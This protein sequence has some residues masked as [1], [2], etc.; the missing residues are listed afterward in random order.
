MGDKRKILFVNDEME[1]GGVARVLNTL[2]SHLDP[3]QYEVDCLVLHKHGLLL[4][5]IPSHVQILSGTSFFDTIDLPLKELIHQK[6]GIKILKKA[7]LIFYM[8]T[9]MIKKKIQA[10]RRKIL[11]KKYDVEFAAKE[12]FCTIFTAYGDSKKKLNW[13]LTDYSVHNY[14]KRH[15]K[16]MKEALKEID[17]NIADSK[18]AL[19]AYIDV[20]DIK[21]GCAIHNLMDVDKVKR[22]MEGTPIV[23]YDLNCVNVISIGRF[24]HQKRVERILYAHEEALKKGMNHNLYLIGGG[25]DE[26][27][28]RKI[29]KDKKLN[30]VFFLGY[31]K[32]P[33]ADLA[34]C[35]LFVLSSEYEGF[36]T[37]VNESLIATT[38]VLSTLV[39][40]IQEQIT[41]EEH[42]WI[43]ENNQESLNEG[44]I[45]AIENQE[46]LRM[47]KKKLENYNYPNQEI[48]KKFIQIL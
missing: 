19:N 2:M 13:V 36:A 22:G 11:K 7:R 9:G 33:Y 15:M 17:L 41:Q 43:V 26:E 21:T 14:S 37:I 45:R 25:P 28:L 10:E 8:K 16:L 47:M 29:V 35:D 1:M 24:H 34:R 40:G 42:G 39:S 12:G 48:L 46:K 20:F 23:D 31:Q 3:S 32:N 30:Q 5:E 18:D 27:M 44:Y 6:K 4:D 38:P